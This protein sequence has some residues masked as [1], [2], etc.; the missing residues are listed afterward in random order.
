MITL[1]SCENRKQLIGFLMNRWKL[2]TDFAAIEKVYITAYKH[3]EFYGEPMPDP[4]IIAVPQACR[5]IEIIKQYII[6]LLPEARFIDYT[7][8]A[9]APLDPKDFAEI[10][11]ADHH[12][13][14]SKVEEVIERT[15]LK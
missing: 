10:F 15:Q 12:Q 14:I 2:I 7:F 1:T 11:V 8:E 4:P 13:C 5:Q 3:A 6:K 9:Q